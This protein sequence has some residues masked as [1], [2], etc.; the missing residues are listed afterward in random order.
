MTDLG[1]I[2]IVGSVVMAGFIIYLIFH[3][4]AQRDQDRR[5]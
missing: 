2:F 1:I 5:Y 4:P 3:K